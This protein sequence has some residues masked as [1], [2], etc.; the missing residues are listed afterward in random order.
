M[1]TTKKKTPRSLAAWGAED[2]TGKHCGREY[3]SL[4][5]GLG[6]EYA[7]LRVAY[8]DEECAMYLAGKLMALADSDR[9]DA[10]T[11]VQAEQAAVAIIAGRLLGTFDA[12]R[13]RERSA[14][15]RDLKERFAPRPEVSERGRHAA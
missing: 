12:A 6:T 13:K 15:I 11:Y 9:W 10:A 1:T 14:L 8:F 2:S 3:S 5:E 4:P 7:L